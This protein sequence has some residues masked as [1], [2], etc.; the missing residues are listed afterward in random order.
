MLDLSAELNAVNYTFFIAQC[1]LET[2]S[3]LYENLDS[4]ETLHNSL[5]RL[6]L[7]RV[8]TPNATQATSTP[9]SSKKL[10]VHLTGQTFLAEFLPW[11]DEIGPQNVAQIEHLTLSLDLDRE[12]RGHRATATWLSTEDKECR[13]RF[14]G[15]ELYEPWSNAP[16]ELRQRG[17]RPSAVSVTVL[18]Y[19]LD[20]FV[21]TEDEFYS[22]GQLE[23]RDVYADDWMIMMF[24]AGFAPVEDS[25]R[26]VQLYEWVHSGA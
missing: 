9:L 18:Y 24:E 19:S 10:V 1:R 4:A 21:D 25:R 17:I 13:F 3:L 6:D 5:A 11:L 14:R 22:D 15:P 23:A 8:C 26:G 12:T 7:E 16:Q 2:D 20:D